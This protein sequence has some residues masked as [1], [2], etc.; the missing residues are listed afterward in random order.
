MTDTV[1][2][3]GEYLPAA[4][5]RISPLDRGVL[6]GDGLFESLRTY[7]GKPFLLNKHLDRFMRSTGSLDIDC[8]V[9]RRDIAE[10]VTR[11][12]DE[13]RGDDDLYIRIT[14]TRGNPEPPA[15]DPIAPTLLVTVSPL[16][17]RVRTTP[18]NGWRLVFSA[19]C[20]GPYEELAQHK[21]TS[22]MPL[23]FSRVQAIAE[24]ADEA[25]ILDFN[26]A[27]LEGT[28]SN[29]FAVIRSW[30]V[31]PPLSAP[32]LPG[33]TRAFVIGRCKALNISV[34]QRAMTLQD[35]ADADVLFATNSLTG[36][37]PIRQWE[38]QQYNLDNPI[39][40]KL[41]D[42]FRQQTTGATP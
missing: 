7:G 32:I 29:V 16:P 1:Y 41:L 6:L 42:D 26:D 39:L 20:R 28:A 5:A 8:P 9:A 33:I 12:V 21:I 38:E 24:G 22:Y 37:V 4:E 19:L 23:L 17:E 27:I 36:I 40:V 30:I 31:T 11:L 10:A 34:K 18:E 25:L 13:R 14:L 15:G 2:I 3:N 35:L